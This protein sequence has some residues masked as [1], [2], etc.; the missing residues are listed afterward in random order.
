[1]DT[2]ADQEQST[3]A[4]QQSVSAPPQATTVQMPEIDY[5]KFVAEFVKQQGHQPNINVHV[6]VTA[7]EQSPSTSGLQS[8][9]KN[10]EGHVNDSVHDLVNNVL[11]GHEPTAP[12]FVNSPM[13][14]ISDGIPLGVSIPQK[15]RDKITNDEFIDMNVLTPS[16][17]ED[18]V[19]VFISQKKFSIINNNRNKVPLTIEQWSSAFLVFMDIYIELHDDQSRPLLKYL[20]NIREMHDLYG[21]EAWRVYDERFRR[22]RETVKLPWGKLVNELYTK[23]ANASNMQKG[24]DNFRSFSKNTSSVPKQSYGKNQFTNRIKTC[25]AFNRGEPCSKP[26]PYKHVCHHCKGAHARFQ[27]SDY[28]FKNRN[29]NNASIANKTTMQNQKPTA[30]ITNANKR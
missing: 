1:M 12:P 14:E 17:V 28:I 6:P 23:S 26:C 3:L 30:T 9:S 22:L 2:S 5:A 7:A 24:K 11:S 19:S 18:P 16:Y 27:C 4:P 13:I 8:Q 25:I 20:H 29:T 15:I 21:D 10:P